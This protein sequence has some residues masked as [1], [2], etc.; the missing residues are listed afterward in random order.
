MTD[1][2][3]FTLVRAISVKVS[4]MIH[5]VQYVRGHPQVFRLGHGNTH[6]TTGEAACTACPDDGWLRLQFEVEET[7]EAT[8]AEYGAAMMAAFSVEF[9]ILLDDLGVEEGDDE[10]P[11]PEPAGE[12]V[13]PKA[14]GIPFQR[15]RF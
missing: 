11:D 6:Q 15:P 4:C 9:D 5:G 14:V 7:A 1:D 2:T 12:A 13:P 3:P 10:E 8:A